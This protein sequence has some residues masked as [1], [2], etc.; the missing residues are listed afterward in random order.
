MFGRIAHF[1]SRI[2]VDVMEKIDFLIVGQGLAG[3]TLADELLR[4]GAKVRVVDGDKPAAASRVA[5]G[6][7]NP[8]TFR[9]LLKSWRADELLPVATNYYLEACAR[10]GADLPQALQILRIFPD[11]GAALRW[12]E[13]LQDPDFA[14]YFSVETPDASQY[15]ALETKSQQGL[16]NQAGWLNL[17]SYLSAFR[18]Y[19][20]QQ[21]AIINSEFSPEEVTF[22]ENGVRWKG[23]EAHK[24]ILCRGQFERQHPWFNWLPLK[25][26]QGDVLTLHVPGL[27]LHEIYNAGF[28]ILPLG[29]DHYRVGATY[30]WDILSETPTESGKNELLQK[31]EAACSL[32]YE[33][34]NHQAGIRPTVADRRPLLGG[35]PEHE[36]LVIFN[37]LGTK[38][39]MIAP[40]FAQQLSQWLLGQGTIED[41]VHV[42]RFRKRYEQQTGR[43]WNP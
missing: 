27:N 24:I 4:A 36:Q 41:E 21:G 33:L 8:L 37:G 5:S 10:L 6:M 13:R 35:H 22:K 17:P 7:W 15:P 26:A 23:I 18:N 3:S 25:P 11:E 28:F 29:N 9:L 19:L 40:F 34:I 12:E 1:C 38:G 43:R 2:V 42:K 39:V 20:E 30:E 16:V 31:F 14:T 32:P